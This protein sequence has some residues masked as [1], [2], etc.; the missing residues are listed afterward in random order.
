MAMFSPGDVTMEN[1]LIKNLIQNKSQME[2]GKRFASTARSNKNTPEEKK[3]RIGHC[4]GE[5]Q[6]LISLDNQLNNRKAVYLISPSGG[7]FVYTTTEILKWLK[8]HNTNPGSAEVIPNARELVYSLEGIVQY[9][10]D[11]S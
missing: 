8:N 1:T 6:C 3:W 4:R 5:N 11:S 10:E 9:Q 7:K 2:S